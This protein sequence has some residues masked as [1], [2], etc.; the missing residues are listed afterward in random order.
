MKNKANRTMNRRILLI[1][2]VL[3]IGSTGKIVAD[4]AEHFIQKGFDVKVAYGR[5]T[6]DRRYQKIAVRIGSPLNPFIHVVRSRLFDES[7]WGSLIATK[8]FIRWAEAYNPDIIWLHN[9]HGYYLNLPTFFN[10]LKTRPQT[11]IILTLHDCW[12]F[13]GHCSHFSNS[14]CE[15][16]KSGCQKCPAHYRHRL[17]YPKT[18]FT[19]KCQRN[20]K[21]KKALFDGI[22]NLQIVTPSEWLKE[23]AQKGFFSRFSMQT[24]HN[25][26]NHGVFY[27]RGRGLRGRFGL[28]GTIAVLSVAN[29][30]T[31]N[32]GLEDLICLADNLD[33]RFSLVMVGLSAKNVD[34]MK[35]RLSRRSYLY[36]K[37]SDYVEFVFSPDFN[38]KE[39]PEFQSQVI[40]ENPTLMAKALRTSEEFGF[41]RGV[42][43][44]LCF[45]PTRDQNFLAELYSSAD[46]FVNCTHEDNYPTVNLEAIS[47]GCPVLSYDVGGCKETIRK[48]ENEE[49]FWKRID[50]LTVQQKKG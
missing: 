22:S 27:P 49:D 11:K 26:I 18:F 7:G 30:W 16:W 13:T 14:H 32:K 35:Q 43:R 25:Q 21:R 2:S 50:D 6:V 36:K 1:N 38:A 15:Q 20:F 31:K 19:P 44:I 39:R 4:Y 9:L 46:V 37:H 29:V 8:R 34:W 33:S 10:W 40:P 48:Q 41:P 42:T 28:N 24:I 3:G 23:E 47:C 12:L 45:G 17:L 5:G